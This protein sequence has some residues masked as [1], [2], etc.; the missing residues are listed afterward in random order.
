[1]RS[2]AFRKATSFIEF[3]G[4]TY[5]LTPDFISE[6]NFLVD[7]G[8]SVGAGDVFDLSSTTGTEQ[9]TLSEIMQLQAAIY[10]QRK[11]AYVDER[12][13]LPG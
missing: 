1:M 10:E 3:E 4:A 11:Q 13:Q 8:S 6:L 9:L 12:A 2:R 7:A 5:R